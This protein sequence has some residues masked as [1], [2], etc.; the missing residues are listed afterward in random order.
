MKKLNSSRAETVCD[1]R[2]QAVAE[3]I[4]SV[5]VLSIISIRIA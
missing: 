5:A 4:L 3:A 1:Q 2:G